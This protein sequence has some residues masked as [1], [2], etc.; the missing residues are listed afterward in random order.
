MLAS[1]VFLSSIFVSLGGS[2]FTIIEL[3]LMTPLGVL[4]PPSH[5]DFPAAGSR[6]FILIFRSKLVSGPIERTQIIRQFE[7]TVARI[8]VGMPIVVSE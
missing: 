1:Y 3:P 7:F 6:F 2:P 8:I 4:P 5:A